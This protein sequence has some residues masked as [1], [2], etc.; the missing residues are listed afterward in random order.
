MTRSRPL[1]GDILDIRFDDFGYDSTALMETAGRMCTGYAVVT[2]DHQITTVE[3]AAAA[4][5]RGEPIGRVGQLTMR[6]VIDECLLLRRRADRVPDRS[7]A[8]N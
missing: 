7:D 2:E 5:R 1:D 3:N 6:L 4:P 8:L